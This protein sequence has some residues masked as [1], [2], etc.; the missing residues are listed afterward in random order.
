[1]SEPA[2]P[3]ERDASG[4]LW[5]RTLSQIASVF[6]RLAWL[7]SLRNPHS[8]VYEHHG[9][10]VVFSPEESNKALR[11]T[12]LVCCR[13][14]LNMRLQDQMADLRLYLDSQSGSPGETIC[15]WQEIGYWR[16]ILPGSI[17]GA[18]RAMYLANVEALL[19]LL[20]SEAAGGGVRRSA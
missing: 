7:A 17:R 16:T 9:L 2:I 8:G 20:L 12:H 11:L 10:A 18:E 14:W 6:G 1:V 5:R 15:N 19:T 13:E 4:V 3:L